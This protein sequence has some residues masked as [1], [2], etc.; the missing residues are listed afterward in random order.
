MVELASLRFHLETGH[1]VL[2]QVPE[3]EADRVLNAILDVDPLPWGDYDRVSYVAGVGKQRFRALS[4][5]RNVPTAETVMVPCVELQVFTCA[6]ASTLEALVRAIY[7]A[8]PYEEPVV[9]I[10]EAHRTRHIPGLDEDN[11][12]RFWNRE[13]ASWVPEEHR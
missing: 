6:D 7:D 5:S 3:P 8:H 13:P 12:N 9:Q 4:N 1:R 10:V 11:P 2:V